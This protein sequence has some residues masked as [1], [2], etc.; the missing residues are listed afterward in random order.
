MMNSCSNKLNNHTNVAGFFAMPV[1]FKTTLTPALLP[2]AVKE[3]G[4]AGKMMQC[5]VLANL[6]FYPIAARPLNWY[7][8]YINK[9]SLTSYDDTKKGINY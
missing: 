6:Y 2:G 1:I 7:D 8:N 3:I 9:A 5:Y 4:A